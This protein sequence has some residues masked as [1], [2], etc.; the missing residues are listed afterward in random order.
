MKKGLIIVLCLFFLVG[1]FGIVLAI[2]NPSS[3]DVEKYAGILGD[4]LLKFQEFI[5]GALSFLS[6][7]VFKYGGTLA[8]TQFLLMILVFMAVYSVAGFF[9]EK[10]NFLISLIITILA[11]LTMD[12]ES[13][14]SI[15]STYEGL[16]IAITVVLPVLIVL[17]FTFRIYERAYSGK[18][19]TSP[20]YAKLFNSAFMI[21]F[22][23]FFIRYSSSEEGT[24]AFMRLV[25]GWVL[26]GFG[27]MQVIA[28]KALAKA[29]HKEY[30][31]GRKRDNETLEAK[32]K[33][34]LES[35]KAVVSASSSE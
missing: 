32:R 13:I 24:I 30:V 14:N 18:G 21:F 12:V 27:V 26:I 16:G 28:Y 5:L 25:S 23:I 10:F 34:D 7:G 31:E 22:G 3:E 19:E 33:A 29:I 9:S 35:V 4:N 17:S 15:L 20:F 8:F 6:F 11:F 1:T 2:E